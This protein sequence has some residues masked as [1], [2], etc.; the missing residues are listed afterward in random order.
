[1][2]KTV[3]FSGYAPVHLLCYLPVYE[4][5]KRD[6]D[7]ELRVA[8]GFRN[9]ISEEEI[10]YDSTGFFEPHA[11][12]AAHIITIEEAQ[13]SDFD[14]LVSSHLSDGLFPRSAKSTVQIFHGVSM[15][16]LAVREKALR[17]DH[18]CLPGRYHAE[19][20]TEQGLVT[21]GRQYAVT[22]FP[23]SDRIVDTEIELDRIN[24]GFEA[25]ERGQTVRTVAA[26][27][28]P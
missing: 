24:P 18:L 5:L 21:P 8:G 14:V 11:V 3:F 25:V 23:K 16:N 20:F 10:T 19:K 7:I 2:A 4:R 12:D 9:K 28:A 27:G 1:M 17:F 6:N 26:F 13:A 15:K 22:G